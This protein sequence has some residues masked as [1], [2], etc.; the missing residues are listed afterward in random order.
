MNAGGSMSGVS[1][2]RQRAPGGAMTAGGVGG[3]VNPAEMRRARTPGVGAPGVGVERGAGTAGV[4][5][6]GVGVE[7]GAGVGRW[8]TQYRSRADLGRYGT[9]VNRDFG[10]YD[11]FRGDWYARYPHAWYSTAWVGGSAWGAA[12]WPTVAAY[13]SAPAQQPVYYDYGTNVVQQDDTA[14]VNGEPVGTAAHYASQA[15]ALAH[16]SESVE[17]PQ[18]EEWLPLGVFAIHEGEET[19][20]NQLFQIAV[21]RDGVL[22]GNYYDAESDTTEPLEGAVDKETGR[23]AWTVAQRK[24][25]IYEAGIANLTLNETTML[26]HYNKEKASQFTLVRIDPPADSQQGAPQGAPQ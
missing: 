14:Y 12:A 26:V 11:A 15:A 18:D 8:G 4:G 24:T 19:T 21:N 3:G 7:R 5:A 2:T 9:A 6:P 23:A 22:R 17:T 20:S 1:A 10:H 25:P 13:T 16:S